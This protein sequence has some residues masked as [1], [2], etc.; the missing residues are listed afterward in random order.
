[1]KTEPET[2]QDAHNDVVALSHPTSG[3]EEQR[4]LR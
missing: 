2:Y 1:M 4:T 3:G